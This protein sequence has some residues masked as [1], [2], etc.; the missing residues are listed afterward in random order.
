MFSTK[1]WGLRDL[2]T[3]WTRKGPFLFFRVL[4]FFFNQSTPDIINELECSQDICTHE[5]SHQYSVGEHTARVEVEKLVNNDNWKQYG[6]AKTS[7]FVSANLS[8]C[9]VMGPSRGAIQTLQ[10]LYLHVDVFPDVVLTHPTKYHWLGLGIPGGI[11]TAA[12][13]I[14]IPI[15][16][17]QVLAVQSIPMNSFSS[18]ACNLSV[19]VQDPVIVLSVNMSVTGASLISGVQAISNRD[20]YSTNHTDKLVSSSHVRIPSTLITPIL[21][22][23]LAMTVFL[24]QEV[25][26]QCTATG[27][28]PL[29][30]FY[31]SDVNETVLAQNTCIVRHV[32]NQTGKFSVEVTGMNLVSSSNTSILTVRVIHRNPKVVVSA[33]AAPLVISISVALLVY[34]LHRY[35]SLPTC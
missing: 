26:I 29:F 15:Q 21:E 32:F 25:Q 30:V 1:T 16:N 17:P 35:I 34:S 23:D 13:N 7:F 33:V 2:N 19:I 8:S 4:I 28:Q 31:F 9:N 14:S 27:S 22:E 20:H 11:Y 18:A 12:A 5:I 10:P 3:F 6:Q 24:E